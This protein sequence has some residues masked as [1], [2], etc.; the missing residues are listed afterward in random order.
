MTDTDEGETV[1]KGPVESRVELVDLREDRYAAPFDYADHAEAPE[2]ASTGEEI[3]RELRDP[4]LATFYDANHRFATGK[5]DPRKWKLPALLSRYCFTCG[6]PRPPRVTFDCEFPNN[7]CTPD[8][9]GCAGCRAN[10]LAKEH[11][12]RGGGR[13]GLTCEGECQE[14]YRKAKKALDAKNRRRE[15]RGLPLLPELG[16]ATPKWTP[17]DRNRLELMAFDFEHF[18]P[19]DPRLRT[20][21]EWARTARGRRREWIPGIPPERQPLDR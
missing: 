12:V 21:W 20:D 17:V 5:I 18:P 10:K 3:E 1:R 16:R 11:E 13:P 14:T 9:P 6:E 2:T 4:E 19:P 8:I 15:A 7:P